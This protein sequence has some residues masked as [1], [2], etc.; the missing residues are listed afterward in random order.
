MF[1]SLVAVSVTPIVPS[2]AV[3]SWESPPQPVAEI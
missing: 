3:K 1:G 2:A